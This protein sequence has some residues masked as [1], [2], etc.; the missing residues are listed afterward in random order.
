M[1]KHEQGAEKISAEP[2]EQASKRRSRAVKSD[3][4]EFNPEKAYTKMRRT[5]SQISDSLDKE[6]EKEL[7]PAVK[8]FKAAIGEY[9]EARDNLRYYTR[10]LP[11]CID[12][13][14][15]R[16]E[17]DESAGGDDTDN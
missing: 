2:P 7:W 14:D 8:R 6:M 13:D 10:T 15:F 16:S 12:V 17:A 1:T 3:T 9:M 11:I 4:S 5:A